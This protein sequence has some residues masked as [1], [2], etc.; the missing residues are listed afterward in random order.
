MVIIKKGYKVDFWRKK[1]LRNENFNKDFACLN[2][3]L[4][5]IQL[6][7][8]TITINFHGNICFKN[9]EQE[10]SFLIFNFNCN[11]FKCF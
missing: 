6:K 9:S 8:L 10:I 4:K 5:S 7:K 1:K 11:F 2:F 3:L